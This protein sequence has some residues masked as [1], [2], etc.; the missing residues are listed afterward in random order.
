VRSKREKIGRN[1]K[2]GVEATITPRRVVT[3]KPSPALLGQMNDGACDGLKD[4][5]QDDTE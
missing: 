2:S 1:P 3:Y 5:E 4:V